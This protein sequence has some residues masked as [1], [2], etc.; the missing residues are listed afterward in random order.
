MA[1]LCRVEGIWFC[2]ES[3]WA[4]H[5]MCVSRQVIL[6]SRCGAQV[7]AFVRCQ[8]RPT[9]FPYATQPAKRTHSKPFEW[10]VKWLNSTTMPL[11]DES[12]C[13]FRTPTMQVG[14][15]IVM[16]W[17]YELCVCKAC[18]QQ[19]RTIRMPIDGLVGMKAIFGL[20]EWTKSELLIKMTEKNGDFTHISIEII[21]LFQFDIGFAHHSHTRTHSSACTQAI[22]A[23]GGS[24]AE[25]LIP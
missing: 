3:A 12:G 13:T 22:F 9:R 19:C 18:Q 8:S 16:F 25:S 23:S 4:I 11:A 14:V 10:F 7:C 17:C 20:F 1:C 5:R 21:P 2:V 6:T 24:D 15:F